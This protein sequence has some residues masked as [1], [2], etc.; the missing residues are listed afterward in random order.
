MVIEL[1]LLVLGI[2]IG[3]N[4]RQERRAHQESLVL[5]NVDARVRRELAVAQNLNDS[6][7]KDVAELKAQLAARRSGLPV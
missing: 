5:E 2:V 6:L 4:I 1:L 3:Y 7:Q